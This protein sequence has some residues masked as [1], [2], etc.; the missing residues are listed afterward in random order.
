MSYLG[1]P[2]STAVPMLQSLL[3]TVKGPDEPKTSSRSQPCVV[4]PGKPPVP[5]IRLPGWSSD[6]SLSKY[7][8]ALLR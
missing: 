3:V 8:L 2:I 6:S 7:D 1:F 5:T 4:A